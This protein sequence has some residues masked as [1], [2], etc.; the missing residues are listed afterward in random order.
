MSGGQLYKTADLGFTFHIIS[1][2]Q[3]RVDHWPE[4][5]E[6][7]LAIKDEPYPFGWKHEGELVNHNNYDVARSS[8]MD[9]VTCQP[10]SAIK[11]PPIS[12]ICCIGR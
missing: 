8:S 9:G 5:I 4:I 2:L 6:T 10:S 12:A 11:S 1:Y 7:T 3:G